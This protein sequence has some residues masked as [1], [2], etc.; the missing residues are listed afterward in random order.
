M[1]TWKK[2]TYID[3]SGCYRKPGDTYMDASGAWRKPGEDYIWI[4]PGRGGRPGTPMLMPQE[5]IGN[6][7]S[8]M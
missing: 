3:A 8:L 6:L 1:K 5:H 2:E 4:I 7:E